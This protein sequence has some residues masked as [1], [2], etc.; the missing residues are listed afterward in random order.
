MTGGSLVIRTALPADVEGM[1]RV[2]L[3]C[4]RR[5]Y[6]DVLPS[7]VIA[8]YDEANATA[9]WTRVL[10]S[11]VLGRVGLVAEL[12]GRIVGAARVG[13]DPDEPTSGHLFS[14]YVDPDIQGGGVGGR[15]L[16]AATERIRA[17]GVTQATLWVFAANGAARGFYARHGWVPD[18]GERVEPE[19]GEPELRYRC[20]LGEDP[21]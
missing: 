6:A 18:G 12:D 11:D 17:L 10:T 3:A 16:G 5:S 15:L 21:G 9:L 1:A 19:Y 13:P 20:R 7:A 2:F 8:L 14:L 4:W